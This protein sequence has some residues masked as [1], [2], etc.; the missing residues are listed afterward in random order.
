MQKLVQI[1]VWIVVGLVL[2]MGL[3]LGLI[4]ATTLHP[5]NIQ[6][7]EVICPQNM[8][9]LKPGQLLKVLTFN[10]QYMAGKNYVFFYDLPNDTGPD[11]RPS[12]EDITQTLN[13]V[14]RIIRDEDPDIILLQEV[15]DGA[16]RTDYQ[17]QTAHLLDLL[18]EAYGCHTSAFYW[19]AAFVPHSRIRGAVGQKLTTISKYHID[20]ATRYQLP[21][22]SLDPLTQLFY[23]KRAILETR[24]PVAGTRD[25]MAL[26]THLEVSTQGTDVKQAE[27]TQID[28]HLAQLNRSGQPWV[29][30]GDFNLLPPGQYPRLRADQQ[31][32][33]WSDT[34]LAPLF[35][36]YPVIPSLANLNSDE[37][38]Q[39]FT[40]LPNDPTI[41]QPDRTID[42]I[43]FADEMTPLNAYVR[44]DD[45][46]HISDHLPVIAVFELP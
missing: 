9:I 3:M 6:S 41:T 25:F 29:L 23:Y 2:V 7:E 46:L 13:E 11:E 1:A 32:T 39:W 37:F 28:V 27:I 16:K 40:A 4:W 19:Q 17:D 10:V 21:L 14:A 45:T 34:E 15:D 26:N 18:P 43:F 44:Q 30:G 8:P 12:R 5:A 35:S 31:N 38:A 22:S 24:L 36:K 33:Y 20:G 42:Y